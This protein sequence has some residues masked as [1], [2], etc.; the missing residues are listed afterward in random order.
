MLVVGRGG[1]G[2]PRRFPRRKVCDIQHEICPSKSAEVPESAT[3]MRSLVAGSTSGRSSSN[4]RRKTSSAS[5]SSRVGC[6]GSRLDTS[7]ERLRLM[8]YGPG[9]RLSCCARVGGGSAGCNGV[10]SLGRDA[11]TPVGVVSGERSLFASRGG[12]NVW[13]TGGGVLVTAAGRRPLCLAGGMSRGEESRRLLLVVGSLGPGADGVAVV[14]GEGGVGRFAEAD[15]SS[16]DVVAAGGTMGTRAAGGGDGEMTITSGEMPDAGGVV[17]VLVVPAVVLE[18]AGSR[19]TVV[20]GGVAKA[21]EV[22][23]AWVG[24]VDR[25]GGA[26][27]RKVWSPPSFRSSSLA[28]DRYRWY[29][30]FSLRWRIW[31]SVSP[32]SIFNSRYEM[33][34]FLALASIEAIFAIRADSG[35]GVLAS[36]SRRYAS[37]CARRSC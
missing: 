13:T 20:A 18:M 27:L 2:W 7:P 24:G 1:G 25:R 21:A 5:S 4:R 19:M 28:I 29:S 3:A 32:V 26:L 16:G 17:G 14:G 22:F 34:P 31:C 36:S 10:V 6:S 12:S 30:G 11:A 23:D 8:V 9:A 35:A 15:V 33:T 37:G